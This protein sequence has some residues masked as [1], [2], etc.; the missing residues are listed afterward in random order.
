[1][2]LHDQIISGLSAHFLQQIYLEAQ[3]PE[4]PK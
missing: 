3:D 2:P 1:M 4:K